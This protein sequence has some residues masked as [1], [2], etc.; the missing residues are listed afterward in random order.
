[1]KPIVNTKHS[2]YIE[3]EDVTSVDLWVQY[4]R[5]DTTVPWSNINLTQGNGRNSTGVLCFHFTKWSHVRFESW[6]NFQN[7]SIF[8]TQGRIPRIAQARTKDLTLFTQGICQLSYRRSMFTLQFLIC[9]CVNI[10]LIFDPGWMFS[11]C[12]RVMCTNKTWFAGVG[13]TPKTKFRKNSFSFV[14]MRIKKIQ[15]FLSADQTSIPGVNQVFPILEWNLIFVLLS[16]ILDRL[17]RLFVV[18][19]PRVTVFRKMR[20]TYV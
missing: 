18:Q 14:S 2:V 12:G 17:K 7:E 3:Q 5:C 8:K 19:I 9:L 10:Y 20:N 15:T 6:D 4:C 11:P 1:M 13:T 16:K